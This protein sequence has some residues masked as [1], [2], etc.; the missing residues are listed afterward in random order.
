MS[1]HDWQA[2]GGAVPRSNG[3]D[4]ADA[5]P[6]ADRVPPVPPPGPAATTPPAVAPG[7]EE[8]RY[9]APVYGQ[10]QPVYGQQQPVYG[11]QPPAYAQQPYVQ[12]GYAQP[13]PPQPSYAAPGTYPPPGAGRWTPPP[14]P[15]LLPLRPLGFGTLLW[16]P[17]RTLRRNPA[18][19]FGSGLVVQL[20]SA[21]ATLAVTVPFMVATFS[22][23]ETATTE[24][25]DAILSGTVGGLVLLML[26]PIA[27]SVVASAFLQ[28]IMVV[29]VATGTIGERLGFAAL[30]KRAAKR[31]GPL[32]G[33]T[34]LLAGALV[35]GFALLFLIVLLAGSISPTGLAV[36]I[37]VAIL[38]GLGLVVL[39]FW[40]GVK[41]SLVPSVIVLE[42]A[43]IREA[44]ARSWRLTDG[45]YWRTLGV[46]LL[47]SVILNFAAQVVVQ[48]VSLVG[49]FLA[50]I[51]D[52]TG[53]GAALA[54]TVITYV[55][56]LVLSLLIGAITAVVQA[57]LV[58]VIYIDLRMRKE[59]LDLELERF[60]ELR[61]A[62]HPVD[63]P[64]RAPAATAAAA[65][66]APGSE[67]PATWS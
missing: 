7:Y 28:G 55:V 46:L 65:P 54:I 11:Q 61:E 16:A 17:F 53:T 62:G 20:V 67:R 13:G 32:I 47:V 57:A 30:W 37:G 45:Y 27:I 38:L 40:L 50:I 6:E 66:T 33:W 35:A 22:R 1:D 42:H 41:V 31:I 15:G 5:A 58:A 34:L 63:D 23:L 49:T 2:P 43:G 8:P 18:P 10:Q 19:T 44:V 39:G 36:G 60:V 52:P 9:G 59:G 24:D 48:P 4:A 14:K 26:V 29:D 56:T 21:I 64:Y 51:I 12:P 3:S 25:I